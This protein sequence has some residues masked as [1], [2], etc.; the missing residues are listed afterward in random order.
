M[1]GNYMDAGAKLKLT[2]LKKYRPKAQRTL[3]ASEWRG[4]GRRGFKR[5]GRFFPD[6]DKK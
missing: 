5:L 2:P 1:C 6:Q 3:R 4:A